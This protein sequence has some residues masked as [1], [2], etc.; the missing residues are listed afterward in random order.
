MLLNWEKL[1]TQLR[2]KMPHKGLWWSSE[3]V[4]AGRGPEGGWNWKRRQWGHLERR[5]S[6]S[7]SPGAGKQ[8]GAPSRMWTVVECC[9]EAQ[10]SRMTDFIFLFSSPRK[11]PCILHGNWVWWLWAWWFDHNDLWKQ[12]REHIHNP[13]A[14]KALVLAFHSG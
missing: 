3:E 6:S 11:K 8:P 10:V 14:C 7:I 5:N 2:A 9:Q 1:Q 4:Q 12:C 13:G